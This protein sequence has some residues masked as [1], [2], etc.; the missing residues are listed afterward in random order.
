MLD[1]VLFERYA[2]GGGIATLFYIEPLA[3]FDLDI[4]IILRESEESLVS[5]SPLYDWLQE[6]NYNPVKEHV[7]IEGIPVQ[8]IPVYSDLVKDAVLNA[9]S[10]TYE[11]ISTF[12]LTP[13]YLIA[14]MLETG[15]SKD[16][17]RII[18]ILD[19]V[20]IVHKK[21]E[22]ILNKYKLIETYTEFRKKYYD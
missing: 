7:L 21:L 15:R 18:K 4:F 17:E 6:R 2:I 9:A 22:K 20:D 11:D 5:L 19:E 3:T 13:E 10:K 1:D 16:R 8:F 14:I 12:V